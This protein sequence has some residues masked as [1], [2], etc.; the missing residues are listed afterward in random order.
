MQ[1]RMRRAAAGTALVLA[2][3]IFQVSGHA[4]LLVVPDASAAVQAPTGRLTT[5]G[6]D[7]ITVNG[8]GARSG[9]TVFSGQQ[10]QTP[11]GTGATVQLGR[12]GRVDLAP[13]T[14]LTLTFDAGSVTVN[15]A[16]G[17][18]ILTAARGVAGTVQT[19]DG[20]AHHTDTAKGSALDTCAA[21]T[22][23]AAPVVNQGA[24]AAAG[25]GA[26]AGGGGAATTSAGGL[27]G[28][29][30]PTTIALLSVVSGVTAWAILANR[31]ACV[32]RGA[33]PSPGTPRGP[34]Q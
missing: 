4:E 24:A 15:L 33:N 13:G 14:S 20:A 28:L 18:V 21:A 25:A 32:P 27:F 11:A 7:P 29:G 12:L 10:I 9:Q 19:P 23:G 17:C 31:P 22:P 16:T 34:C 8:T 30:V 3:V 1:Q 26:A 6:N 5:S 2:F